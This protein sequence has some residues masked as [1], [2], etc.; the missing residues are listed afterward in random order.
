MTKETGTFEAPIE[1]PLD[2]VEDILKSN[3]WVFNRLSD[4]ELLVKV[5]GRHCSYNLIFLWQDDMNA[6]QFSI[7][8][9]LHINEGKRSEAAH[10]LMTLN[11]SLGLGHFSLPKDTGAPVFRQTC[12]FRG[13][14]YESMCEALED[15]VDAGLT[16]CEQYYSAFYLLSHANDAAQNVNDQNLSLALM[17]TVG[18]C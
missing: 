3:N 11:E 1:N 16:L 5:A 13:M 8:Y 15:L 7:Q 4:E 12:L 14:G 9:D 2:C 18:Q 10:A 6:L 17:E